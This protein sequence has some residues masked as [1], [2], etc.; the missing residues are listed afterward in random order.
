[1]GMAEDYYDG[2]GDGFAGNGFAS[3][4]V[5]AAVAAAVGAVDAVV[6]TGAATGDVIHTD[7]YKIETIER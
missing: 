2:D 7:T 5:G 3:S 4:P 1:M 6:Q